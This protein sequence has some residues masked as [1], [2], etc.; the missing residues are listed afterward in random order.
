[1]R[2]DKERQWNRR[3]RGD[4]VGAVLLLVVL[5]LIL[6]LIYSSQPVSRVLP[7][8]QQSKQI[9]NCKQILTGC[10]LFAADQGAGRYPNGRFDP[11]KEELL[12]GD[13]LASAEECFQDLCKSGIIDLEALFYNNKSQKQC[14]LVPPDEDGILEAGENCWDYIAG[15]HN[16]IGDKPLLFE[17]SDSGDG[18]TW[19]N[20][21]GHPWEGSFV[22]GFADGSTTR[23]TY[24]D[25]NGS[26]FTEEAGQI[27]LCVPTPG[28]NE[29]P[30]TAMLAPA[31]Q[32]NPDWQAPPKPNRILGRRGGELL[33]ITLALFLIV[34]FAFG[35]V[36][37][38]RKRRTKG[39]ESEG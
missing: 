35:V 2:A 12:E 6:G 20:E 16:Y 14:D 23:K 1:M 21:G 32:V 34:V 9:N 13:P 15:L 26:A 31:T 27:D 39:Q 25:E 10:A 22:V 17:A 28:K 11:D 24:F 7:A 3:A 29:W 4:S 5:I 30:M 18:R 37:W 8:A 33:K 19:T 38:N 36:I